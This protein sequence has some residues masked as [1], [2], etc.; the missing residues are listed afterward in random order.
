MPGAY[1]VKEHSFFA[2][3]VEDEGEVDW[4][5]L[6]LEKANFI[7]SLDDELD[8][9]YFDDRAD[10]YDPAVWKVFFFQICTSVKESCSLFLCALCS[11]S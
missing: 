8:T 3:T 6:L 7:P 10:R 1:Y 11:P 5:N 2:A 4:D 9:S